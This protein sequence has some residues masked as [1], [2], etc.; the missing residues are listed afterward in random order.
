MRRTLV[1][2]SL[3]FVVAAPAQA[4]VNGRWKPAYG[5]ALSVQTTQTGAGDNTYPYLYGYAAGSE[6]DQ[7]FGYVADDT[8]HLLIAGNL[9]FC[10]G[11]KFSYQHNLYAFLDTGPGGQHTLR[12]DN[13][14]AS[15]GEGIGDLAGLTFDAGFAPDFELGCLSY[16]STWITTLPADTAATSTWL[17]RGDS[18]GALQYG[19]N[20]YGIQFAFDD[21]N[22]VGVGAGCDAGSGA[23]VGSGYEWVV[24]LTALGQPTGTLRVCVLAAEG[25]FVFNQMLAPLPAGTCN[26]GTPPLDLGS[27]AGAQWFAVPVRPAGVPAG[28]GVA[29]LAVWRVW[30][31]PASGGSVSVAFT[32]PAQDRVD[33][34]L[35]DVAGRRLTSRAAGVL[36]AGS[37][38][39]ALDTS[40]LR[41]GLCLLRLRSGHAAAAAAVM[42]LR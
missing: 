33:V 38:T 19:S 5:A 32:L 37:H 35:V 31:N 41:P 7:A 14:D 8:L 15:Y 11:Q 25:A 6:L 23:G 4:Q 39:L 17:G 10:C 24:P 28:G 22:T 16:G 26:P 2:V 1:A 34:E 30:P 36:P 9:A 12:A 20:P 40:G 13:R 18:T 27:F 42:L 3:L 29:A 21:T